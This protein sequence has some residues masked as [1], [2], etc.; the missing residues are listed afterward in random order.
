MILVG[1]VRSSGHR[2][3]FLCKTGLS[4]GRMSSLRC[5]RSIGYARSFHARTRGAVQVKRIP[6]FMGRAAVTCLP[7]AG[8][9]HSLSGHPSKN[10]S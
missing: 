8:E 6:F 1:M 10:R 9:K 2:F 4:R 3:Y 5:G 7:L